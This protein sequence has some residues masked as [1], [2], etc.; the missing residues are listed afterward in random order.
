MNRITLGALGIGAVAV[1]AAGGYFAGTLAHAP[2]E[3]PAIA[4]VAPVRSSSQVMTVMGAVGCKSRLFFEKIATAINAG[5]DGAVFRILS[6]TLT[7]KQCREIVKDE[8]VFVHERSGDYACIR[9]DSDPV[10]IWTYMSVIPA[11]T[12]RPLR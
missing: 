5:D 2:P 12:S 6:A 9:A 8:P 3:A 7:S 10:C 1:V 11:P 4:A